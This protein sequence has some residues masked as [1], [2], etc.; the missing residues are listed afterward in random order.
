[1]DYARGRIPMANSRTQLP[2]VPREWVGHCSRD[3]AQ[4]G[5]VN[6]TASLVV[7]LLE[8]EWPRMCVLIVVVATH[9]HYS[10]VNAGNREK[11]ITQPLH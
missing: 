6:A 4:M 2:Q 9:T 7:H 3:I 10:S 5:Q 1:M 8:I 11:Y